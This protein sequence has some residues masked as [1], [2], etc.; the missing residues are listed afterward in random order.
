MF[1]TEKEL[2]EK[3]LFKEYK[4][5]NTKIFVELETNYGRP[6]IVIV[7]F[8]ETILNKRINSYVNVP[9]D[10][11]H[12]YS[13]TFLY[14]KRW[15]RIETLREFL[16]INDRRVEKVVE[17]LALKGLIEKKNNL[18]KMKKSKD[19]L[20]IN[21]IKVFE[22][23]LANWKYV[24]EQAERHLWFTNE[25]SVLIPVLSNETLLKCEELCK[26]NGI[27]LSIADEKKVIKKINFPPK[28]LINTPLLWEINE[29]LLEES[30]K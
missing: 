30:I 1:S 16:N 14:N 27:G 23:K 5:R 13:L 18:I 9:F 6:D 15:I 22:A 11:L 28:K 8:N 2:V 25:S 3:F 26:I 7:T 10:R 19:I 20:A 17:Q 12:S 24:I 29:R 4:K 21:R